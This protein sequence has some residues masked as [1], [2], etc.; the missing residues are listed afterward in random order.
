MLAR[1]IRRAG[2]AE[3]AAVLAALH[4]VSF[5]APQGLVQIDADNRHCFLWPRIGRSRHD[6]TFEIL[7]SSSTLVRPD[8]YLVWEPLALSALTGEQ[9]LRLVS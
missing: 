6:G 3:P 2:S 9:M 7:H 5:E 4:T 8:P 1:A